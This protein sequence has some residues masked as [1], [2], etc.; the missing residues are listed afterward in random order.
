LYPLRGAALIKEEWGKYK[1][2][3]KWSENEI[4]I[5]RVAALMKEKWG[6]YKLFRK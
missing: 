3:Q 6:E 5:S 4:V 1:Q 2:Y